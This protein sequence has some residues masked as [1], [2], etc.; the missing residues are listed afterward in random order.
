M[1]AKNLK[2]LFPEKEVKVGEAKIVVKPLSLKDLPK[3]AESFTK[4]LAIADECR[5]EA[6]KLGEVPEYGK[7]VTAA[8]SELIDLIP[9]CINCP[10]EEVP[11]DLVPDILEIIIEQNASDAALGKWKALGLKV[12]ART[13]VD[14]NKLTELAQGVASTD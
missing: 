6:A 4:I 7:I 9:F 13:G 5:A 11:A 1:E 14:L 8:F 2:I 12:A 10:P 3:V